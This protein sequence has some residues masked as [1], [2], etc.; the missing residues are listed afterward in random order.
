LLFA[1]GATAAP[2]PTFISTVKLRKAGFNAVCDTEDMF[3]YW[4]SNFIDRGILPPA[5]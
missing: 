2:P 3:R 4:L 5:A 1:Y